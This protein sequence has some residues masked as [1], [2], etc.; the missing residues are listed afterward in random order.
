MFFAV[1]GITLN[2]P[3]W[4]GAD[5]ETVTTL[6][7]E[8]TQDWL[9]LSPALPTGAT[10]STDE[11]EPDLS[12]EIDQLAVVEHLRNTHGIRG[13]V[14]EFRVDE[15]E[16]LILFRGPSY[17]AEAYVS[18]ETGKYTATI[19]ALGMI[20]LI[21]DLHKGRDT[22][23]GWSVVI[24]VTAI[25]MVVISVTGLVLILYIRRKRR[26]GLITAVVGTVALA[27]AYAIFVP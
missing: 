5:V 23:L 10:S 12:R 18:R 21:N 13:A 27:A 14:K 2:H 6:E 17:S 25:V 19:T 9:H 22:G 15:A 4:F 24:D 7:G 8:L 3:A 1:T 16:C 11:N 20:A 26:S